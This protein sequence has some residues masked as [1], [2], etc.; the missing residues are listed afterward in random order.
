MAL[1]ISQEK[2]SGK[3]QES[4]GNLS[5]DFCF[6]L[7]TTYAV[8]LKPDVKRRQCRVLNGVNCVSR[9]F[10]DIDICFGIE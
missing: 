10:L 3:K 6:K 4:P 8:D 2:L 1:K 5:G 9:E 7:C